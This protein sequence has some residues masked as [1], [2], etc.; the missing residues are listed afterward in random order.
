MMDIEVKD[1]QIYSI[2]VLIPQPSET[3]IDLD[4]KVECQLGVMEEDNTKGFANM[5]CIVNE[6]NGKPTDEEEPLNVE[7]NARG[8]VVS[9][10]PIE[11][12]NSEVQRAINRELFPYVRAAISMTTSLTGIMPINLPSIKWE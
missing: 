2:Q 8:I 11:S 9:N 10:Q 12:D 1:I 6:K 5:K 4:V 3:S 7:I